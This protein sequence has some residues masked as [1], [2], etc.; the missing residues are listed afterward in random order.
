MM[1][2]GDDGKKEVGAVVRSEGDRQDKTP[3]TLTR[4]PRSPSRGEARRDRIWRGRTGPPTRARAEVERTGDNAHAIGGRRDETREHQRGRPSPSQ[5]GNALRQPRE[6]ESTHPSCPV[7]PGARGEQGSVSATAGRGR[8]QAGD[9]TRPSLPRWQHRVRSSR[10]L[11]GDEGD[12]ALAVLLGSRVGS[13]D[14]LHRV[15]LARRHAAI[16]TAR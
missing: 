1:L 11:T 15:R 14:D 4:G 9:G 6:E 3:W 8:D 10:G 2:E 12:L 5:L 7:I 16:A 13:L